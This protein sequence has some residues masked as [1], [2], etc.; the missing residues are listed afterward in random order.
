M[1]QRQHQFGTRRP[2]A[3]H[4][5]PRCGGGLSFP[6]LQSIDK[7]GGRLDR[8]ALHRAG[9]PDVARPCPDIQAQMG[10][11]QCCAISQNDLGRGQ[12]KAADR[13]LPETDLCGSGMAGGIHGHLFGRIMARYDTG[14]HACIDGLAVLADQGDFGVWELCLCQAAQHLQM[15]KAR[16]DQD[17]PVHGKRSYNVLR[18]AC[19]A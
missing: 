18:I 8:K 4:T 1:R 9:L 7:G 17:Q 10:E 6:S 3:D 12:I 16:A 5:N 15:H 2:A 19:V 14:Q 11:I 13:A